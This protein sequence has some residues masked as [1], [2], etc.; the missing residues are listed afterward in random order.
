MNQQAKT[1]R[2]FPYVAVILITALVLVAL[3]IGYTVIDSLGVIGKLDKAADSNN[4]KLTENHVDVYRYHVAQ[5]QLYTQFMYYQYGLIQDTSGV[6]SRFKTAAE[7][8]NAMIPNYVGSGNFDESAYSY[9]EQY[10]TY[11]EGAMEAGLYDQYKADTAADIDDYMDDL[12]AM[13]KANGVSLTSYIHR[14]IGNGVSKNDVRKAMEYYF[15]GIEY[16]DKLFEEYSDSV[17][18]DEIEKYRD[19]HKSSFFKTEYTYYKLVNNDLKDT[20]EACKTVD[21]VKVALV[22]YYMD[23]K[24]ADLYKSKITDA[25]ITDEAGQEQTK[26]DVL[27][28]VLALNELTEDEAVFKSDDTDGYKKAAYAIAST[29]STE[30]STQ[31]KKISETSA[32]Y[33]DPTGS[34]A[35]DLQKWLF[36]A[37]RKVGD[38]TVIKTEK[39]STDSTT[40]ETTT[41][42]TYTWYMVDEVMVLDTELTKNAYYILLTDDDVKAE[43]PKTAAQKAEAFYK[44]LAA[45]KTAEKFAELVEKYAP[46]SSANLNEKISKD[47]VNEKLGEWLYD[48][49]RVEGDIGNIPVTDDK[50]KSAG[51]YVVYYVD[52]NEET[53]KMN[54]RD[55]VAGEKLNDWYDEAVVKYNVSVDYEFATEA[56]AEETTEAATS[57]GSVTNAETEATT[58]ADTTASTEVGTENDTEATTE[59]AA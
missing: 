45:D 50:G 55:A 38:S 35:T 47:A 44:E 17:T 3:I 49:T 1:K 48:I 24:F 37:G 57:A 39:S 6:T 12:E 31:I 19:E 54:A 42:T 36:G 7:Y 21:E 8:A 59:T 2:E 30:A 26:A 9:A 13:A 40:N 46:G 29:I 51:N 33:A 32:S 41:T 5:N 58:V 23:Q 27:T 11:C 28:T 16:A 25:S 52:Q 14:W 53:W 43:N 15:I 4:F 18:K 22:N 56:P 20:I 34:S 10:L